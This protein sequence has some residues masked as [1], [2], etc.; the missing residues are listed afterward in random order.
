VEGYIGNYRTTLEV[1]GPAGESGEVR[2]EHGII[3]VAT[4]AEESRPKEYRYGKDERVITQVEL[5]KLMQDP[6]AHKLG[7]LKNVV[8]I[9]CVGSR[10]DEHPYCSRVCCQDAVKNALRLRELNPRVNIY[11]LYRD[12][13]TYG[14]FEEYYRTARDSGV[15]FVR[16]DE[17]RKPVV[18]TDQDKL[19]VK[20]RDPVL[21]ADVVVNPDLVVL[22]PAIVPHEDAVDIS[23]MLKVP[24]NENNFFLEAHVK[25]RPVDF[26]TEGVFLA[27]MAH[28]P[29]N[30]P[31]A[32]AQAKAA[33]ARAG[34]ILSRDSYEA[35]ATTS[36]VDE[37]ICAGCGLCVATCPYNAPELVERTDRMVSHVNEALCKGC[38]NCAAV[39]PSGAI[40]HLGFRSRQTEV[41]LGA[42]LR[43]S[44]S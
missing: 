6:E 3:I 11:V 16:Y 41:M 42:A 24:L 17:E 22:A 10:D 18:E 5:E 8:M 7:R 13:R 19:K 43:A 38:G 34:T 31:E 14:F 2:V 25:L 30:I 37:D 40:S 35:G 20:M 28:S 39:C 15:M 27:G 12:M 33:A 1:R 4:G 26:S 29:K 9:Q 23:R 21:D 36:V 32:I 44:R